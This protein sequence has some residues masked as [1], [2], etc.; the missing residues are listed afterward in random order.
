[1]VVYIVGAG[2]GDIELLTLKAKRLV[3]RGDVILYDKLVNPK[4]LDWAAPDCEI[5]YVGKREKDS[6]P[7]QHIQVDINEL[8]IEKGKNNRLV[9]LKGGDPFIFGRGGEEAQI[10]KANN[11]PFE[12]V[13]GISSC[14]AAPAYSGIPVSH[15]EYNSSF[16]V[17]TG[18]ESD[19]DES[20]IDW[21]HLPENIVVLMGVSR[22][23]H[24]AQKLLELGRPPDTPVG[25]VRKGTTVEQ[26]TVMTTLGQLAESGVPLEPPVA[27]VIGPVAA[28]HE[29]LSWFE[30]KLKG[31]QGKKI[32]LTRERGHMAESLPVFETFGMEVIQMPLIEVMEKDFDV[33]DINT[34]DALVFTSQE[35]V[36]QA[37]KAVDIGSYK[38]RTFTIGPKTKHY[39]KDNF[40]I[41]ASMGERY[42][43]HGLAEHMLVSLEPGSK[44]LALRSSAATSV[45]REMLEAKFDYTEI[46]V[47]D[48]KSLEPVPE[49]LEGADAVFIVSA[50]CGKAVSSM[51]VG[52]L[53]GKV[54]VSIGPE[55]SRHLPMPHVMAQEHT[56]QGMIDAYIDFIWTGLL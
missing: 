4:I 47:Y 45:I 40:E 23:K 11:I 41:N 46:A 27:F 33:P 13:P 54:I 56:I 53:E 18:H 1:M 26:K 29:E 24:T 51:E 37:S 3:E 16:A 19:K 30:E 7:S 42:N 31:A 34:F 14:F 2:P 10:C 49:K 22:I 6:D 43:S 17:L 25:A 15:R 55:T 32:V 12:I 38:G 35:G 8:L 36:K 44:I 28:L 20:S 52:E 50:S 48:I 21:V 39:L 5:I 9:R